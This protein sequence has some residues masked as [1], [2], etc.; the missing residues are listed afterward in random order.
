M[1]TWRVGALAELTGLTVRAL[2]H[3]DH[4]GLLTPSQRTTAGHRLYTAADVARLYR[5]GLLRRLGFPLAQ[6]AQVL[7]DPQWQLREAVQRHLQ[8]TA[9]RVNL[10]RRRP[11][12]SRRDP[13]RGPG[14][15]AA[16][17]SRGL[18]IAA[19]AGRSHRYD[20]NR[21]RR[22]PPRPQRR[23]RRR[24]HRGSSRPRVRGA[25]VRSPRPRGPAVVILLAPRL[26]LRPPP[27]EPG[28][29]RQQQPHMPLSVRGCQRRPCRAARKDGTSN[30]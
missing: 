17:R 25:G 21:R 20:R 16:S 28:R 4:L 14:H 10:A 30:R 1:Q 29:V 19:Q 18:P 23:R 11:R 2:H 7:E 26:N 8:D 12:D 22:R 9:R 13:S 15:L 24:D 3:Y 5:I 6:I 27:V